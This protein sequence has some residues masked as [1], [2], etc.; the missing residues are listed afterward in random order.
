VSNH[1]VLLTVAHG[2][3]TVTL[4]RPDKRNALNRAMLEGL[5]DAFHAAAAD[6][7]VRVV[8]LRAVGPS[9]CA[10]VDLAELEE[11]RTR[12]GV[13]EYELLPDVFRAIDE[14][15]NPTIAAVQGPALAGGCEIALHCDIRIA[16]PAAR[17]GMPL[18]RLGMVVPF[19]AA[20]RLTDICGIAAARD[21]LLAAETIDGTEAHR[22]GMVSRLVA[23][24]RLDESASALAARVASN[25]PLAV[26]E[27]KRALGHTLAPPSPER[28]AELDR[29]RLR[30]SRSRDAHEG[31]QAFLQRRRP[32]FAGE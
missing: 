3:A 10:G 20:Q 16:T 21:L 1:V 32:H 22:I 27:I 2:V 15:A 5:L 18:A 14:H 24:D 12:H 25:A 9:F 23:A 29:E 6:A 19:Y 4:N 11:Y 7:A 8:L 26:R 13:T 17:F 31:L 30:V 28:V